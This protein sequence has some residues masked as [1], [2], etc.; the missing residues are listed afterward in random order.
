MGTAQKN[1]EPK[2]FRIRATFGC[3][4][5][6]EHLDEG[7][8][9]SHNHHLIQKAMAVCSLDHVMLSI[10]SCLGPKKWDSDCRR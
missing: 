9:S 8:Y 3:K 4:N 1:C 10:I 5:G 2:A 6:I 7:S